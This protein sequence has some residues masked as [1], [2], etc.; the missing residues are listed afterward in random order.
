MQRFFHTPLHRWQPLALLTAVAILLS[1][2]LY[3][4]AHGN[5]RPTGE[6]A[7]VAAISAPQATNDATNV[8]Y[9]LTYTGTYNFFRVYI[10]T[11]Q[12]I[13]TGFQANGIGASYL[14]E[15]NR[16]YRYTG[17][18]SDWQWTRIKTITHTKGGGLAK[19]TVARADI[20]ESATPNQADL[21]FQ[22]EAPIASTTKLTHVYSG[23]TPPTA[24]PTPGPTPT[25]SGTTRTVTYATTTTLFAN[26]ERGFY[27]YF[28]SRSSTPTSWT[29][30]AL[31]NTNAVSWLTAA[32]EATISQIYCLFYLDT[33]LKSNLNQSYLNHI[34]ANLTNIRNAGRKC[35][36]R[37]AYTDNSDDNNQNDIPDIL[38]NAALD[39][40]P[41][42]AQLLGHID[43]LKPIL[44]EYADV[45]AVLQAGFIGIWGEWYYTDHFVDNPAQP[46]VISAQQYERRKAVVLRLLDA[47]PAT[48]MVALRYPLLKKK[49]FGRE[50]PI[51][52]NEA[53]QNTPLARLGVHND[54]FL[55]SYG[56]SGTFQSEADRTYLQAES[57]YLTMGGEVNQPESGA[58]AR[59]CVNALSEMSKYHWSYINTDYYIP[60]LQSWKQ[61]RCIHNTSNIAGSMLDRLGY[62]LVLKKGTYPTTARPGGNLTIQIE[63]VNEGF[64]APF[65][66]RDLYLVLQNKSTGVIW[67]AK[68][69]D[70][71]RRWLAN[72]QPH[73]I[74]R[75]VTLPTTLAT[76]NYGV[77]L[78]LPDPYVSLNTK[79]AYSIRFANN[80]TWKTTSGWNDLLHTLI[81]SNN[82]ANDVAVNASEGIELVE[83]G[84]LFES[85]DPTAIDVVDLE[86]Q[87]SSPASYQ[88]FLPVVL[89]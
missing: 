16:L 21:V 14:V 62:R 34:R 41:E 78:H 65:N 4:F 9:Q 77:F 1:M 81:V 43:Q 73:T 44:Q 52:A 66:P 45:I 12:S 89:Q 87:E 7:A 57:L 17:T 10:D 60:T 48:R 64:A 38:E 30:A 59:G 55:N 56:D 67:K 33:F 19:W 76:G 42:L 53:F 11:D 23:T 2:P 47:L 74:A 5:F 51:T 26:P 35:I 68:L 80:N 83:A 31:T 82:P 28:E 85:E 40:E 71:P 18:G 72:G 6:E 88:L 61:G 13:N 37:F 84:L 29:V 46:D 32:E 36:L 79:P 63:L 70:D 24:T 54:A 75:T 22:V 20:G 69:P 49:M 39:T 8:Y 25:P 15:N 86:E 50:T 27:R 58:P 3:T